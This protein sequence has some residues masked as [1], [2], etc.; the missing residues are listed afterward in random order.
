MTSGNLFQHIHSPNDTFCP[1]FAFRE[2]MFPAEVD[3][4][5]SFAS[6]ASPVAGR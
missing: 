5:K 3:D 4:G 2:E 1:G 6:V